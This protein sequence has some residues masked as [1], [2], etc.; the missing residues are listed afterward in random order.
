MK[1]VGIGHTADTSRATNWTTVASIAAVLLGVALT[2]PTH[3][4]ACELEDL[5]TAPTGKVTETAQT[6]FAAL[7]ACLVALDDENKKL[8]EALDEIRSESAPTSSAAAEIPAGA[9]IA[10]DN[11]N[12]CPPG[13]TDMGQGWRGHTLVAAV[14]DTNDRFGFRR[15]GGEASVTLS[16][17]HLPPH[18]HGGIWGGTEQKAGMLNEPAYHSSGYAQARMEGGGQPH[19]NMPPY[20]ALY[21]CKKM[22]S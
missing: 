14:A 6:N 20:I 18:D 22:A 3:S 7:A 11:P 16:L 9:V 21:F 5:T 4:M 10:F 15:S 13:W 19:E 17:T 2:S 1:L 8:R 12:G